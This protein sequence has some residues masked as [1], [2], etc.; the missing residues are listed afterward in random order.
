[1]W[2][3]VKI[4]NELKKGQVIGINPTRAS[5]VFDGCVKYYIPYEMI[6]IEK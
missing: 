4:K 2:V 5:V 3:Y 1:M 6:I